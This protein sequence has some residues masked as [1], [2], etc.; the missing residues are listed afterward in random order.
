[1]APGLELTALLAANARRLFSPITKL[2]NVYLGLRQNGSG[3]TTSTSE[4]GFKRRFGRIAEK[5]RFLI[6]KDQNI[7]LG[8]QVAGGGGDD[9][10]VIDVDLLILL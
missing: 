3:L 5:W 8:A 2:S 10:F 7:L 1:M 6:V 4:L 9:G